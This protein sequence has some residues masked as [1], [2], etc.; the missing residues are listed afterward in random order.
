MNSQPFGQTVFPSR[1]KV[2][3]HNISVAPKMVKKVITNLHLSKASGSHYIPVV[4]LKNCESELSYLL[5]ELF[6]KCLKEPCFS[7]CWKV[8]LV[9][10]VFKNV[11]ERSKTKNYSPVSLL[12]WVVKSLKS[13]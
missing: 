4:V 10:P 13:L 5:A 11:C 12:L 2:K 7:D 6:N 9:L 8:S 3:L 1:T